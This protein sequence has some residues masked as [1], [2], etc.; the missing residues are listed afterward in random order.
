MLYKTTLVILACAG[1]FVFGDLNLMAQDSAGPG[2]PPPRRVAE[3]GLRPESTMAA[4][5]E[6][7][8]IKDDAQWAQVSE[9]IRAVLK[10]REALM[11]EFGGRARGAARSTASIG[12]RLRAEEALFNAILNGAPDSSV[13]VAMNEVQ[14]AS[15]AEERANG[16]AYAKAQE[17]LRAAVNARQ[18]GQLTLFG[19]LN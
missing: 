8:A 15:R 13:V 7:L 19:I 2:A 16:A 12:P 14:Y 9:K 4:L 5:R 1:G 3:R 10:A 17:T 6:Q 18:Q 11:V